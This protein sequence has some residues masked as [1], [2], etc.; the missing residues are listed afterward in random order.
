MELQDIRKKELKPV[1]IEKKVSSAYHEA[2]HTFYCLKYDIY[3]DCVTIVKNMKEKSYGFV[4]TSKMLTKETDFTILDRADQKKV[5]YKMC[6]AGII[7]EAKI[8]GVYNYSGAS[9]DYKNIDDF[10][11]D[12]NFDI[13]EI[14]DETFKEISK[15]SNWKVIKVIAETLLKKNTL[16]RQEVG[17]IYFDITKK[18]SSNVPPT[19]EKGL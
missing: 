4:D 8:S 6:L 2:G 14:W 5:F 11:I 12:I 13:Q 18:R 9:Q 7:S 10:L 15:R 1:K 3:F 16:T 19:N 17:D